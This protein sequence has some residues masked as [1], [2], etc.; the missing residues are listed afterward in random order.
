M[1]RPILSGVP[2]LL[3]CPAI[4]GTFILPALR[5]WRDRP[6]ASS[7]R[8]HAPCYSPCTWSLYFL[9]LSM[10][11][12]CGS[13]AYICLLTWLSS[14]S[15]PYWSVMACMAIHLAWKSQTELCLRHCAERYPGHRLHENSDN[16]WAKWPTSVIPAT[17]EVKSEFWF[18]AIPGKKL[19]R[20]Y[21]S[22]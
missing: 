14:K 7:M 4:I 12:P 9:L 19:A 16:S 1:Q 17:S 18:E 6:H 10:W 11:T 20:P 22:Q 13:I 5:T 3:E 2:G 15:Y 8:K 21:L